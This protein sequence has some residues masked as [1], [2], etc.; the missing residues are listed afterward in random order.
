MKLIPLLLAFL[1]I[2]TI[3]L[4]QIPSTDTVLVISGEVTTPLKL[5]MADLMKLPHKIIRG[6]DHDRHEYDF[7]GIDIS[8]LL[9]L[10]GVRFADTL[11]GAK[12]AS[13]LLVVRA[14]DNYQA[15]FTL[16]ELD[17][18][19][20]DNQNI[21]AYRQDGKPL[22]SKDGLLRLIALGDK[23]HLRWVRQVQSLIVEQLK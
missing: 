16:P 13:S 22:D 20:S 23:R 14:A 3:S 8:R 21:L 10:A 2:S 17:P 12:F 1:S 11:K 18:T 7:E 5:T 6:L 4:S 15:L 9:S 19:N